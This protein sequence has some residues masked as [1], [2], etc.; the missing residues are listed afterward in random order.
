MSKLRDVTL[1]IADELLVARRQL[2]AQE[3]DE[4]QYEAEVRKIYIDNSVELSDDIPPDI[5]D[6]IWKAACRIEDLELDGN[7][8]PYDP[9]D[10]KEAT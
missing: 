4:K 3:I 5:F 1:K 9:F 10:S 7:Y 6:R 8:N 2:A